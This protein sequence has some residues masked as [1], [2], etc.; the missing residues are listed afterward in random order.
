[1]LTDQSRTKL[2]NI[3]H[4]LQPADPHFFNKLR[5]LRLARAPSS[6]SNVLRSLYTVLWENM[7][8]SHVIARNCYVSA[9][10]CPTP[11]GFDLIPWTRPHPQ[12]GESVADCFT[13]FFHYTVWGGTNGVAVTSHMTTNCDA[14]SGRYS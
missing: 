12:I 10:P 2:H 1:M 6:S 14:Y 3:I 4:Y 8:I 13:V 7:M 11:P 9:R 5:S